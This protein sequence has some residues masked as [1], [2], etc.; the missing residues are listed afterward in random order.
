MTFVLIDP[1]LAEPVSLAQAKAH[2]RVGHGDEDA[3]ISSLIIA[4]RRLVEAR[5]GLALMP[6]GWKLLLDDWPEDGVVK[7]PLAPV[8]SVDEVK[9]GAVVS[10]ALYVDD[11]PGRRVVMLERVKPQAVVNGI[12]IKVTAGFAAVPEP[13][14]QAMLQLVA[15]WFE[16]RGAQDAPLQVATLLAPFREM[17][18]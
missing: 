11:A 4:A 15:H 3:L 13:L 17:K 1:P 12:E 2:L 10:P 16:Y 5:T 7:L 18:I 14:C 6:Q 9:A 8:I